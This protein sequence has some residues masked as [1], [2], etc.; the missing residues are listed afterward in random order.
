MERFLLIGYL[1]FLE[2]SLRG[3][4]LS[5]R[6]GTRFLMMFFIAL[7]NNLVR[8]SGL[9]SQ[10][11]SIRVRVILGMNMFRFTLYSYFNHGLFVS[12]FS[13]ASAFAIDKYI[14]A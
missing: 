6:I 5:G 10:K 8:I 14:V 2:G 4:L 12:A 7:S 9:S 13:L 3:K 11:H 1:V